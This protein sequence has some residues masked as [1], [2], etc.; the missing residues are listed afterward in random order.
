MPLALV[1]RMACSNSAPSVLAGRLLH[2]ALFLSWRCLEA[3]R[4]P[5]TPSVGGCELRRLIGQP[6]H[7]CN[8][9]LHRAFA[10][11]T[12]ADHTFP[13]GENGDE[14]AVGT[15]LTRYWYDQRSGRFSW[16]FSEIVRRWCSRHCV[17]ARIDLDVVR[18]LK[19]P[20]ALR[21]YELGT[22]FV[23]RKMPF[24]RLKPD[25][26]MS[27]AGA[28]GKYGGSWAQFERQMLRPAA[29]AVGDNSPI[30]VSVQRDSSGRDRHVDWISLRFKR[31][32]TW[33]P[34]KDFDAQPLQPGLL[35]DSDRFE[36]MEASAA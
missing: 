3:D 17:Y 19:R 30:G 9:E 14:P 2:G 25:Q 32:A 6:G 20:L 16:E 7:H 24:V 28:D 4:P 22:A 21:L 11:L 18:R 31:Q 1:A 15:I 13:A 12:S 5:L 36:V 27:L 23:D 29:T 8:D 34:A 33:V 35:V 26:L 10:T